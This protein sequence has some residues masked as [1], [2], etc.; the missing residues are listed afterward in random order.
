MSE[1]KIVNGPLESVVLYALALAEE[2]MKLYGYC[3][4]Y[5]Y[6]WCIYSFLFLLH[7]FRGICD[8]CLNSFAATVAA[9]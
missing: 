7:I 1:K 5:G 2:R 6:Y 8:V 4:Y 9:N 3:Y